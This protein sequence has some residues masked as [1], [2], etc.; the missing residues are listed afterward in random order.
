MGYLVGNREFLRV[1]VERSSWRSDLE[2]GWI[3][4]SISFFFFF[5]QTFFSLEKFCHPKNFQGQSSC[6]LK[7]KVKSVGKVPK[8]YL[9]LQQVIRCMLRTLR[10]W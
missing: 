10:P 7:K 8:G 6:R 1:I 3:P 2:E 4:L 5:V 9:K